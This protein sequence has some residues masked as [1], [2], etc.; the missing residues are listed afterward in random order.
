MKPLGVYTNKE[1]GLSELL[2]TYEISKYRHLTPSP[3]TRMVP[4]V[5]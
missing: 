1:C 4:F 2:E 3:M 5:P